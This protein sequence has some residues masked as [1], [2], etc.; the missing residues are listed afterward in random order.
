MKGELV[1]VRSYGGKPLV[2]RLWDERETVIYITNDEQFQ[3]L[4]EGKG[5]LEPIGFPRE[6]VFK[7]DD[8]LARSMDV[9]YLAG[10]WDWDKLIPLV[11]TNES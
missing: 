6:D 1:I 11:S 5:G 3:L 4:L 8:D 2:R 10:K 7:Y 9:R